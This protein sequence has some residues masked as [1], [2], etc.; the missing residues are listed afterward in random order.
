M[1]ESSSFESGNEERARTVIL[2]VE[3]DSRTLRLVRFILEEEGFE[4]EEAGNGADA[5]KIFREA[6]PSLVL[7]DIGLPDMDGFALCQ[8]IRESSP[9]PI[10]IVTGEDK[11]E[12]KVRG[13]ELGADDYVTKPFSTAELT[14][15]VKAV[16]RRQDLASVRGGPTPNATSQ[17]GQ[18]TASP[19]ETPGIVSS[20]GEHSISTGQASDPEVYEGTVRLVVEAGGSIRNMIRFVDELRQNS[21][22]HLL[23][24]VANQHGDGKEGMD[25]L[26]RLREPILL[27]QAL[28]QFVEVSA[29][30]EPAKPSPEGDEHS[31]LVYLSE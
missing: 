25:I 28:R 20:R 22:F 11:D 24:L 1:Q 4:V 31:L 23:R 7:M 10:I 6:S 17:R 12:D 19:A 18:G 3:D 14:A 29:V 16:L 27:K 21:Q 2:V 26:L 15:R 8:Q 13:L 5:L 9:V 30:E